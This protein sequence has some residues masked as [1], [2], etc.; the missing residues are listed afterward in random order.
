MQPPLHLRDRGLGKSHRR[1]AVADIVLLLPRQCC[2]GVY[3]LRLAVAVEGRARPEVSPG[4][5][6]GSHAH[7][8][9]RR[10]TRARIV[11]LG[12][13]VLAL[14]FALRDRRC[15][16]DPQHR[17]ESARKIPCRSCEFLSFFLL[18][19]LP[20]ARGPHAPADRHRHDRMLHAAP[21]AFDQCMAHELEPLMP[22]M[23]DRDRAAVHVQPLV[24]N[25]QAVSAP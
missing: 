9:V 12:E 14:G 17:T 19:Q 2:S 21:P 3:S 10:G 23:S 1:S 8:V 4:G 15:A 24:R 5:V 7:A 16:I 13:Q 6:R 20:T 22:R 18:N 11:E 25:A